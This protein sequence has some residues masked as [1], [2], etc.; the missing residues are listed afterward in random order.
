MRRF[1]P[2]NVLSIDWDYFVDADI[3]FRLKY[4]PDGNEGISS[5]LQNNIWGS[6]YGNS[7][8]E[9]LSVGLLDCYSEFL[10]DISD[11]LAIHVPSE[12][13]VVESHRHIYEAIHS[14]QK[15]LRRKFL[16]LTNIDFHHDVYNP[17][18]NHM[19]DCG[20]WL[21]H[22]MREFPVGSSSYGY[23]KYYWIGQDTSD[24]DIVAGDPNVEGKLVYST[25]MLDVDVRNTEWDLVFLCRSDMW[26]PP[27]LDKYFIE[28]A[29][30]L[31]SYPCTTQNTVL[32]DRYE[33]SVKDLADNYAKAVSEMFSKSV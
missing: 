19:V 29:N 5:I 31:V 14:V 2:I 33:S 7:S 1:K 15:R 6:H 17:F 32:T 21:N 4:F 12:I 20:N 30:I 9:L 24:V 23:S 27:H 26:S 18:C 8:E 10:E 28:L 22:I 25:D 3:D 13:M 11:S 16:D